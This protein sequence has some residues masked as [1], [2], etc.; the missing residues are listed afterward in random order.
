MPE[1]FFDLPKIEQ[2]AIL[3]AAEERL[4]FPDYIIE[5]DFWVCWILEQL[6]MLPL[7]MAFKG[8][9]S[10]SKV[11]R[12]IHRFS[13]DVDIT[14]DYR[15]VIDAID[16]R[17]IS[18]S[19]LK[20]LEKDLKEHLKDIVEKKIVPHLTERIESAVLTGIELDFS[21]DGESLRFYYPTVD[22]RNL[23]YLRT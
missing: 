12:L 22:K 1:R 15:N 13:E 4:G 17:K 3:A 23:G 6:F 18:R 11:Y 10:L 16:L 21:E 20:R 9:T 5:K 19:K 14:I 2:K 7:K 8:G